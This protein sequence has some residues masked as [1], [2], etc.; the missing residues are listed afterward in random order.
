[1]KQRKMASWLKH[2]IKEMELV[3]E[4]PA[5]NKRCRT[6]G[7]WCDDQ[8]KGKIEAYQEVLDYVLGFS[9][10]TAKNYLEGK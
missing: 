10:L 6:W 3:A 8:L 7:T 9:I 1:M 4:T 5:G 2:R